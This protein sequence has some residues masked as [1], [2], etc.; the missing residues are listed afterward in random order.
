MKIKYE[1]VTGEVTQVEVSDEIGSIIIES[2]KAEHAQDERQR[3]H[4]PYSTDALLFEGLEYGTKEP[5]EDMPDEVR[6]R[7]HYAFS[8]LTDI[9]KKRLVLYSRGM[10]VREIAAHDNVDVRAVWDSIQQARNKFL[11]YF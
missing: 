4:C 11:K 8:K 2:R 6:S 3:Y 9:Q 1:S 7:I 5:D 10:T